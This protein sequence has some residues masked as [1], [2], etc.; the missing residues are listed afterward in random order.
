M[1]KRNIIVEAI[2]KIGIK[3]ESGSYC[4]VSSVSRSAELNQRVLSLNI[5]ISNLVAIVN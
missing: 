2:E 3:K 1:F 4:P 5:I